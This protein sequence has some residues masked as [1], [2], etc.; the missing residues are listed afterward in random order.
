[1]KCLTLLNT[2]LL[3]GLCLTGGFVLLYHSDTGTA[4]DVPA[5]LKA[6]DVAAYGSSLA[7]KGEY[8]LGRELLLAAMRKTP[9]KGEDWVKLAARCNAFIDNAQASPSEAA[10]LR[11]QL[12]AGMLAAL[13]KA[14]TQGEIASLLTAYREI[15]GAHP[16]VSSE[17]NDEHTAD[18]SPTEHPAEPVAT[19]ESETDE[20]VPGKYLVEM[21][22][23]GLRSGK[24]DERSD[25]LIQIALDGQS[26]HPAAAAELWAELREYSKTIEEDYGQV[27]TLTIYLAS[28][29]DAIELCDNRESF[30]RLWRIRGEVRQERRRCI[31]RWCE[32]L[33]TELQAFLT[34][35]EK[36]ALTKDGETIPKGQQEQLRYQIEV[37]SDLA[38]QDGVTMPK[39]V[40]RI[41][42]AV[43]AKLI[44]RVRQLEDEAE[45]QRLA[46]LDGKKIEPAKLEAE[47]HVA[48]DYQTL[49]VRLAAVAG[50]LDSEAYAFWLS[51]LSEGESGDSPPSVQIAERVLK[52]VERVRTLQ[53]QRYNLWALRV[54]YGAG[55]STSW[56]QRLGVVETGHLHPSVYVCYSI[57]HDERLKAE[58]DPHNRQ[59]AVT[60]LLCKEKISL[61]AF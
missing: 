14:K 47:K 48:G 21:L 25:A 29:T 58:Q 2:L 43:R 38:Q 50:D 32:S 18:D 55:E 59:N 20:E 34:D 4:V 24:D 60:S 46:D 40:D 57:T 23:E 51:R 37:F 1:M 61:E 42:E 19:V 53:R 6:L 13:P 22:R 9:V 54:V 17:S 49:L 56:H 41:A 28:I 35:V 8:D 26:L 30:D 31:Q 3:V 44:D 10:A 15:I 12:R 27:T 39:A 52:C 45:S 11:E 7:E 16:K 33:Q 5:A 36:G